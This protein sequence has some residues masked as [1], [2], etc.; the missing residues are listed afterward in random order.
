MSKSLFDAVRAI[1]GRG[2][3]QAEV[4]RI[5]A[6][7]PRDTSMGNPIDPNDALLIKELER[8]EGRVLH[9]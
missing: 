5:N 4:D 1:A 7:L 6:A 2:L 3:T 9:A 8:D